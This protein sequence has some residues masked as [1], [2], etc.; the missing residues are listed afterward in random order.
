M[1]W[2]YVQNRMWYPNRQVLMHSLACASYSR[3]YALV[4]APYVNSTHNLKLY[5]LWGCWKRPNPTLR[6]YCVQLFFK[7]PSNATKIP[8]APVLIYIHTFE[9]KSYSIHSTCPMQARPYLR[10]V[11][12]L[13]VVGCNDRVRTQAYST[14]IGTS[15]HGIAQ[16]RNVG[17]NIG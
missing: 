4:R 12:C 15:G 9:F 1:S 17:W 11:T 6:F 13:S 14:N 2:D 8:F 16:R 5:L 3:M 7:F 10:P